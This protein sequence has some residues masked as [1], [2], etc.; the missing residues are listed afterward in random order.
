MGYA[1]NKIR[2]IAMKEDYCP[3]R[4]WPEGWHVRPIHRVYKHCERTNYGV[5]FCNTRVINFNSEA[6]AQRY[7]DEKDRSNALA[8]WFLYSMQPPIKKPRLVAG[9]SEDTD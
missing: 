5:Y 8:D 4:I 7:I 2:R 9:A 6:E 3:Q 1:S